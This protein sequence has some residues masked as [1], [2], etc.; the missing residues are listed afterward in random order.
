MFDPLAQVIGLLR[1]QAVFSKE[2]GAAGRWAVQYV[3]FGQPAFAAMLEGRCRLAVEGE[4]PV[5]L[6]E[7]DGLAMDD[8]TTLRLRA[9]DAAE[10]LVFDLA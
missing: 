9:L 2:I 5:V 1:P 10:V 4:D 3:G 6:E 8:A 7:G